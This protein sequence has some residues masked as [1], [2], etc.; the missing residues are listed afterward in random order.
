ML[1]LSIVFYSFI[2]FIPSHA[3]STQ[4]IL[5]H[6]HS[7]HQ[8]E[9]VPRFIK[10]KYCKVTKHKSLP[11][12]PSSIIIPHSISIQG[13]IPYSVFNSSYHIL[14]SFNLPG[15]YQSPLSIIHSNE[16]I[17]LK[18]YEWKSMKSTHILNCG[19]SIVSISLWNDLLAVS[20][21]DNRFG[22]STN[23]RSIHSISIFNPSYDN[24][25]TIYSLSKGS[26]RILFHLKHEHGYATSMNWLN[27]EKNEY[28]MGVLSCTFIDGSLVIW[29]V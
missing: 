18:S 26:P 14:D 24:V 15:N 12:L 20:C 11:L 2:H 3:S 10:G 7:N 29:S 23:H 9:T 28:S 22:F 4:L 16:L 25:I 8:G 13:S 27:I 5:N 21:I 19:S 1:F 6:L 17:Q